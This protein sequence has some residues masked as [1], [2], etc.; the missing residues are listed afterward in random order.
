MSSLAKVLFV[1]PIRF[2]RIQ[3]LDAITLKDGYWTMVLA[4][5][6]YQSARRPITSAMLSKVYGNSLGDGASLCP[7]P[8]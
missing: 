4:I 7:K 2:D 5:R 3:L 6:W 1:A 8:G